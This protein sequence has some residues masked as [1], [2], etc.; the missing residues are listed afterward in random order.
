[1][2]SFVPTLAEAL[3]RSGMR[4]HCSS[5]YTSLCSHT[6]ECCLQLQIIMRSRMQCCLLLCSICITAQAVPNSLTELPWAITAT[7]DLSRALASQSAPFRHS[8][9]HRLW[10]KS[11]CSD[12]SLHPLD[13]Q[14]FG[15]FLRAPPTIKVLCPKSTPDTGQT[16]KCP[17]AGKRHSPRRRAMPRI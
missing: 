3:V 6:T 9:C 14:L 2:H 16:L 12:C 5:L 10:L 15:S 17:V 4:R 11:T 8:L 1:M 7:R 13:K